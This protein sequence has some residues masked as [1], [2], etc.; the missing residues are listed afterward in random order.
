[1][2]EEQERKIDKLLNLFGMIGNRADELEQKRAEPPLTIEDFRRTKNNASKKRVRS[3]RA[4]V[5]VYASVPTDTLKYFEDVLIK[6]YEKNKYKF[7]AS[8][9]F[10]AIL[11]HYSTNHTV[12]EGCD[13]V[14]SSKFL[15]K[16][17]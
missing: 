3:D 5:P 8:D 4:L 9:L 1:M 12:E 11:L 7:R 14:N 17:R 2:N 6:L 15:F 13:I 10:R 16:V